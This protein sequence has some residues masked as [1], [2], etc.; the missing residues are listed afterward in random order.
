MSLICDISLT[1]AVAVGVGRCLPVLN[2]NISFARDQVDTPELCS[3]R[4]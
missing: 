3:N 4:L 2:I 1:L